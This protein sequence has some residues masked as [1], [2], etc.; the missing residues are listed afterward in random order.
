MRRESYQQTI[1]RWERDARAWRWSPLRMTAVFAAV[2]F[3]LQFAW[4]SCRGGAIERLLVDRVTV[5]PAARIVDFFWPAYGA[6]AQ[7][8]A[9]VS[10]AG[11]LN[12]LNGCEGLE[13]VFLLAAAFA[14]YP[15][16]WRQ[17][18]LGVCLGTALAYLANQGRLTA[19][20]YAFVHDRS[21]FGLLHGTVAPLLL[22]ALCLL[23]FML[24]VSRDA[25]RTD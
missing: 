8:N 22:I 11:R 23:Y 15:M 2:F 21:L 10:S 5:A 25:V 7:A 17:R 6:Q 20:W 24:F 4:E 18:T 1:D 14:A 12:V 9:I 13:L 16:S 3:S 19:L